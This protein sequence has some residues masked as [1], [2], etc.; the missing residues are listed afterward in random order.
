MKYYFNILIF[1]LYCSLSYSQNSL[2]KTDDL[3]RV[4]LSTYISDQ[5]DGLPASAKN[6]LTNKLNQIATT[7]GLGGTENSRF[8]LTPNITLLFK[9]VLAGPPRRVIVTLE[10]TFYI[11]DGI[12]GTLFSSETLNVKGV[13]TSD[14]KAYISAIKQIKA[15]NPIFT[16]LVDQGKHKIVEYYNSQCDFI[17]KEAEVAKNKKNYDFAISKLMEIPQVTKGCYEKA[18]DEVAIVYKAKIDNTCSLNLSNAQSAWN[19]GLDINSAKTAA[20]YLSLIDPDSK[21]YE[22]GL[23]LSKLIGQRILEL[24][25]REWGFKMKKHQ[26]GIDREKALINAALE[27]GVAQAKN[28]PKAVYNVSRWW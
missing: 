6:L 21:C 5:I 26:D 25:Q 7:N 23:D 2:G 3:G 11:G 13:G 15:Q 10:I 22:K 19:S 16:G 9:E 4:Q 20:T 24:D 18:M 1:I 17:L 8:I 27:I 28:Q 12:Q 14:T